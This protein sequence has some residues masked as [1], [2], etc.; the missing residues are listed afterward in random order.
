MFSEKL[1]KRIAHTN[2]IS[3]STG[4]GISA[5]SGVPTFRGQDGL[6]KNK[7]VQQLATPQALS[8]DPE[9]FWE[10]YIY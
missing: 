1:L 4:A 9:L 2:Y 10:F 7:D 8:S 3:V 5:E 6:W